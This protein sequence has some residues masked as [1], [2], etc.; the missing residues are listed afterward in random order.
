M[1]KS[2][3][4][5][6][7]EDI[8][9]QEIAP[10]MRRVRRRFHPMEK[11]DEPYRQSRLFRASRTIR[12]I[13]DLGDDDS[14]ISGVF[15]RD[16]LRLTVQDIQ[17]AHQEVNE[18]LL[19]ESGIVEV[20]E[21]HFTEII[22]DL[23]VSDLPPADIEALREAGSTD[24]HA[25]LRLLIKTIRKRYIKETRYN[26][27]LSLSSSVH[28]AGKKIE[29]RLQQ[30]KEPDENSPP[31]RSW[32]K[33]LGSLCRGTVLTAV[34]ISLLGGWW[35]LPLSPDTAIVGS[36]ASIATGLGDIAIGI[37]EFRGE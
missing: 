15:Q 17:N 31:K 2:E 25:E 34:D 18:S 20:F 36:V 3:W 5:E 11:W 27:R 32:F 14:N 19:V 8:Y 1:E 33:G 13:E 26:D 9:R 24:P 7:V 10:K 22:S 12:F 4:R 29:K 37:G 16:H 28:E 30:L 6:M 23:D 21:E 35:S